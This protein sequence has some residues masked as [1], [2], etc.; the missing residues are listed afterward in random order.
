V[1]KLPTLVRY[2][3][4]RAPDLV[5]THTLVPGNILWRLACRIAGIPLVNHI[6][7]EN[8]FGERRV[9]ARLVRLLDT[10]TASIPARHIAVSWHTARTL[11][12]QGYPTER[13]TGVHNGVPCPDREIVPED[14]PALSDSKPI[15]GCVARLCERK[16]Q[17]D[18]LKVFPRVLDLFPDAT[19]WLIG[20]DQQT[21]GEYE[22][23]LKRLAESL[24]VAERVVFWGHQDDPAA[25]MEKMTV[26]VLPSYD[27]GCPL[28]LLEAMS[29]GVPVV[30]TRV[31]GVPELISDGETGYLVSPGDQELL[32]DRIIRLLVD[33]DARRRLSERGRERV[34]EDFTREHMVG[35]VQSVYSGILVSCPRND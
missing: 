1:I 34:M 10:L 29:L 11:V 33:S 27:E 4:R 26:L 30:A 19:L 17:A 21:G 18:L 7:I 5:H 16:G 22:R 15:I 6:H 12:E 23:A 2:L 13:L 14:F 35:K 31:A 24:D 8:Y 32:A 3:K 9:K 25:L 20:K 28:V